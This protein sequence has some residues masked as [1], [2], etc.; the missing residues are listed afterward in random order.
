M[1]TS[2]LGK[3]KTTRAK[4]GWEERLGHRNGIPLRILSIC[5]RIYYVGLVVPLP[6][7]P[8]IVRVRVL[9]YWVCHHVIQLSCQTFGGVDH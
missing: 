9:Y 7:I 5:Y 1:L 6:S 4:E 3:N 8:C 2:E